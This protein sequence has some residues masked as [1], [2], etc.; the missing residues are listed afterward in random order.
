MKDIL[1]WNHFV[2][3]QKALSSEYGT[4]RKMR[5]MTIYDFGDVILVPFPFTDHTLVRILQDILGGEDR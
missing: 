4:T 3:F 1:R 2:S 5:T